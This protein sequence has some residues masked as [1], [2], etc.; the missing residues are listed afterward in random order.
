[1]SGKAVIGY[2]LDDGQTVFFKGQ[3][4]VVK[5]QTY[6][7]KL[8]DLKALTGLFPITSQLPPGATE[9]TWRA[10]KQ[11]G[12]AKFISDYSKAFPKAD[13]GGTEYTRRVHDIGMSYSYSIREIQRAAMANFPLEAKR[14]IACRRAI[15]EKLNSIALVGDTNHNIPGFLA[16]PGA[17]TYTVPATGTGGTKTWSTKTA[18]HILTDLNGMLNAINNVTMGKE[19]GNTILL[20]KANLDYIKQTRLGTTMEKTIYQFF[21]EN[22]PGVTLDWLKDLD[23]A[24]DSSTTRMVAYINDSQH[25]ELEI[26][27]MFD[28]LEEM[29]D[30]PAA[31]TVPAIASTVGVIVYYPL[32]V[33]YGDGI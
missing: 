8:G 23:T 17:T 1:M 7:Q 24:G 12:L 10:F 31:Y 9:L 13:V 18:D 11:Y 4:E 20:P 6:D 22:N 30:G 2:N 21:T 29:R 5:A 16:Y 28:V 15:D 14:A 27:S 26:P 33:V 19:V 25:L 3:L 32:T